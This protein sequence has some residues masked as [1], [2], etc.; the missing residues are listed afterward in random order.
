[1]SDL[2]KLKL[3]FHTPIPFLPSFETPPPHDSL[4]VTGFYALAFTLDSLEEIRVGSRRNYL[5]MI[6]I[7][8]EIRVGTETVRVG[9][10][11]MR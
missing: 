2:G 4:V 1:M 8:E 6:A 3:M 11:E 5:G 7:V 10:G 9:L